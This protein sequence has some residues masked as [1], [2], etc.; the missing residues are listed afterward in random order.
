[1]PGRDEPRTLLVKLLD[2][3]KLLGRPLGTRRADDAWVERMS[4]T[5]FE[6]SPQTAADAVAATLA[7]GMT[8]DAV[9]EAISLAAN[10]LI[11]RDAGRT[12]ATC[13]RTS[14][15]GASTA[16]PSAYTPAI[17]PTPGG[18]WSGPATAAMPSPA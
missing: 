2:Q 18:T 3:Y 11:L 17:R 5:I 10:Q 15:W 4:R 6:P 16:I 12:P 13:S 8:Y 7:E 9:G 14:H 1:M